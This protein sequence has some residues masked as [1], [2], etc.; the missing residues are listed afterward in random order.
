PGQALELGLKEIK[1]TDNIQLTYNGY[2]YTRFDYNERTGRLTSQL[3]LQRGQNF[4][5]IVVSNKAGQAR[6]DMVIILDDVPPA[7]VF[8]P[9]VTILNVSNPVYNSNSNNCTVIVSARLEY[10]KFASDLD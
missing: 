10:V 9:R 6:E 3:A 5:T 1:R 7:P 4:L 2:A 8:P